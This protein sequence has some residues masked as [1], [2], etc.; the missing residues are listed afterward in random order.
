MGSQ[1]PK[2]SVN[3]NMEPRVYT[4]TVLEGDL[5]YLQIVCRDPPIALVSDSVSASCNLENAAVIGNMF[6]LL[7]D[8]ISAHLPKVPP[9]NF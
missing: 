6:Q 5:C 7:A 4:Y 3:G 8:G 2:G 9:P 1:P